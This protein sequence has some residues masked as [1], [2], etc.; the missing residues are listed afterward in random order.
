MQSVPAAIRTVSSKSPFA[1]F[2]NVRNAEISGFGQFALSL[3]THS[4]LAQTPFMVW[5]TP[6]TSSRTSSHGVPY[7]TAC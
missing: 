2:G 5:A 6:F 4:P 1:Q 7:S 3:K